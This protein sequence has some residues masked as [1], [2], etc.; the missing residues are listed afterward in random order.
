MGKPLYLARCLVPIHLTI[1]K[2]T[3]NAGKS[4][5][6]QN[7]SILIAVGTNEIKMFLPTIY[8]LKLISDTVIF[9]DI[10]SSLIDF[11]AFLKFRRLQSGSN[12]YEDYT[13]FVAAP[14]RL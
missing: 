9:P 2:N 12:L 11:Q 10:K 4:A 7:T 1:A 8:G 3:G 14:A 6:D 5:S 13:D